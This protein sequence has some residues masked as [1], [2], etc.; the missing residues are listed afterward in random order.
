MYSYIIGK[1]TEKNENS[2]TLENGG[3]GYELTVTSFAL[4]NLID[5]TGEV[6]IF[7][8]YQQRD[9]GVSLFG[10]SSREEKEIFLKLIGV[11]G[12]GPKMAIGILSNIAFDD[13][14]IVIANGDTQTLSNVK[15]I[16]KKTA[17]RIVVEL[18]DKVDVIAG[19]VGF[20]DKVVLAGEIDDACD[21][22]VSLGLNRLEAERLTKNCYQEG[23]TVEE[24]I[25]KALSQMRS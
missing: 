5:T 25:T 3:I 19:Q 1:I 13:L 14:C 9:D 16:G 23:D 8:Y 2:I 15:G 6:K 7:T 22:L 18:K 4:R 24:L 12:I 20:D 21:A 17:E 10:F 11:T